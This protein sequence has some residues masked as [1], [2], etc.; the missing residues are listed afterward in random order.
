MSGLFYDRWGRSIGSI[1][2][3]R[4]YP[5]TRR[6]ETFESTDFRCVVG[7]KTEWINVAELRGPVTDL[8]L[9]FPKATHDADGNRIRRVSR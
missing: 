3:R 8:Y 7:P 5:V 1:D 2:A 9:R 4:D 6:G